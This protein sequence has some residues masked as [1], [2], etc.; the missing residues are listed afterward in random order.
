MLYTGK[1]SESQEN[2]T[3]YETNGSIFAIPDNCNLAK[4]FTLKGRERCVLPDYPRPGQRFR[5]FKGKDYE[6]LCLALWKD[7]KEIVVVY[8]ALYGEGQIWVRPLKMFIGKKEVNGKFVDRFT[9][10]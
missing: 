6:V 7:T 5:H 4:I 3:V 9:L 2:V 1:H 10:I 8:K